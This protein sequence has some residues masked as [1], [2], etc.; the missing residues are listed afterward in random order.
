MEENFDGFGERGRNLVG[1]M[2]CYIVDEVL[3]ITYNTPHLALLN[4]L[5]LIIVKQL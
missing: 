2:R 3:I 5:S 4:G 1:N